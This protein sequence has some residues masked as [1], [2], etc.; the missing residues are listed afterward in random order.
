[1]AASLSGFTGMLMLQLE[2][3]MSTLPMSGAVAT[4]EAASVTARS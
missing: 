4:A 3:P 1:M 2:S